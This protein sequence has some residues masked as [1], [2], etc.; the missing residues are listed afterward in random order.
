LFKIINFD[1]EE[2]KNRVAPKDDEEIM[3]KPDMPDT[4][5]QNEN[6]DNFELNKDKPSEEHDSEMQKEDLGN[7]S[8][9]KPNIENTSKEHLLSIGN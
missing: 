4:T 5:D 2:Q 9:E 6:Q 3:M 7:K 8:E 1:I